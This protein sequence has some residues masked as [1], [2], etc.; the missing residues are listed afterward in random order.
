MLTAK[1]Q[2]EG[3]AHS[4][5]RVVLVMD[6]LNK[7]LQGQAAPRSKAAL[8]LL[9]Q[10]G[11]CTM[12]SPPSGGPAGAAS[13]PDLRQRLGLGDGASAASQ[14]RMMMVS[15]CSPPEERAKLGFSDQDAADAAAALQ[16]ADLIWTCGGSVSHLVHAYRASGAVSPAGGYWLYKFL[17][18]GGVYVGQSAGSIVAGESLE[19]MF[20]KGQMKIGGEADA[21]LTEHQ[22]ALQDMRGLHLFAGRRLEA[23]MQMKISLLP[24][25]TVA[26]AADK[27][28]WAQGLGHG[29]AYLTDQQEGAPTYVLVVEGW[30]VEPAY[31]P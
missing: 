16:A 6:A 26:A 23:K 5:L 19:P 31:G 15:A 11:E 10:Q 18:R 25:A 12:A 8:Q 29:V 2:A 21:L 4:S 7:A 9:R 28:R 13:L 24:H 22:E 27:D 20:W 30:R 1:L 14:V 17:R 3:R